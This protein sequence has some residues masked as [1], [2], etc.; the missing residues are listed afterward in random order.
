LDDVGRFWNGSIPI[1][2]EAMSNAFASWISIHPDDGRFILTNGYDWTYFTVKDA[3]FLVRHVENTPSGVSLRLFDG[4][5]EC[6]DPSTVTMSPE[7]VLYA[8]VKGG[9][10]EARFS[11]AAQA[12]MVD[13]VV[14]GPDGSP[15]VRVCHEDHRISER[16]RPRGA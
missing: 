3:P 16:C 13:S 8:R 1:D 7:G 9:R 4:T 10:F 12:E 15:H 14:E 2:H 5:E 11:R 6:L